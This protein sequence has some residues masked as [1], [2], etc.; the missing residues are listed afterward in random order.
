MTTDQKGAVA[1]WSIIAA[2]VRSGFGVY[3][4]V[5]D[6]GR[7]DLIFEREGTLSRVQCKWA[8]KTG[9]VVAVRCYS[10]C[11]SAAGYVR[12]PYT[13]DEVDAIAAYCPELDRCFLLPMEAVAGRVQVQL[14]LAPTRNNQRVGITWARD[15]ELGATLGTP[16]GP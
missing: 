10:S 3:R 5:F 14:R 12:H 9:D 16:S 6:G 13:V 1:E 15:F 2:A 4:P 8:A 7:Y 11:R